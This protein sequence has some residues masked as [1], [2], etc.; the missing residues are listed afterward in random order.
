[1]AIFLLLGIIAGGLVPLQTSFNSRL[2]RDTS[3]PFLASG[4]SF[5]VGTIFLLLYGITTGGSAFISSQELSTIPWWGYL[6]GVLATICLTANIFMFD[7]LGSV[8]SI[9]LPMVGQIIFSLLIDSFGWFGSKVIPLSAT[10]IGGG[11]LVIVGIVFIVVLPVFHQHNQSNDDDRAVRLFWT[12]GGLISGAVYA[13]E[14]AINGHVGTVIHSPVHAALLTFFIATI[15]LFLFVL[16]RGHLQRIS[17]IVKKRTPWWA[18]LGG[19]IGGFS[20]Y[21]G[22]FLVPQIGNGAAIV[23]GILGQIAVSMLIDTFGL[24]GGKRR[25]IV[26]AQVIG[27]VVLISGIVLIELI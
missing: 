21:L 8:L 10:R 25:P 27:I 26:G 14:M 17:L 24:L 13:T 2:R 16:S 18:L 6:G 22:A 1:M 11:L 15:L 12:I 5:L 20:V 23:L 9:I 3:E 7:V 19:V 4:I